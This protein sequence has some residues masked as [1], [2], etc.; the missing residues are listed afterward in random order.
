MPLQIYA[1]IMI[2]LLR[3][4]PNPIGPVP[5]KVSELFDEFAKIMSSGDDS[6]NEIDSRVFDLPS[7]SSPCVRREIRQLKLSER[8]ALFRALND[9]KTTII[10]SEVDGTRV[11]EYDALTRMHRGD[12]SPEA[13]FGPAF[14]PF[15][16]HYLTTQVHLL[17]LFVCVLNHLMP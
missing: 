15:H 13:H 11:S 3:F 17:A 6:S 16:R 14:L 5:P 10:T 2:Q 7:P 8:T 1:V 12:L 4:R 9:M